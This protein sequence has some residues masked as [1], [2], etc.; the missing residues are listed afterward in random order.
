MA[1]TEE[2]I[3]KYQAFF[4]NLTDE[5]VDEFRNLAV[6]RIR[7][8]DPFM[9]S[10]GIDAVTASMHKWF[11]NL[12][13]IQFQMT[14][15]GVDGFMVFQHWIMKFRIRKLPKRLWELEGIS[16]ITFNEFGKVIDQIDYWDSAPLLESIPVLGKIVTLLKKFFG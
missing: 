13:E 10:R 14:S 11:K 3:K 5:N 16:K 15:H 2:I 6:P 9:D 8:Q 7:Y 4:E 1:V 12:T